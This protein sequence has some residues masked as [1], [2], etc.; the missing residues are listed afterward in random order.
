MEQEFASSLCIAMAIDCEVL[1]GTEGNK[2][3]LI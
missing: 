3:I 1:T 2:R